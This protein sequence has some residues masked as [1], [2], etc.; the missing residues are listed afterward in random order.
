MPKKRQYKAKL[1]K[2]D[3]L[4]LEY[5]NKTS[6]WSGYWYR[7]GFDGYKWIGPDKDFISVLFQSIAYIDPKKRY[8]LNQDQVVSR[9]GLLWKTSNGDYLIGQEEEIENREK[10]EKSQVKYHRVDPLQLKG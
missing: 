8:G 4:I 9:M 6:E 5:E 3:V 1:N 7:A 10:D 2:S